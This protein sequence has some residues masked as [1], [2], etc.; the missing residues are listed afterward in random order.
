MSH[1]L[2]VNE[3]LRGSRLMLSISRESSWKEKKSNWLPAPNGPFMM[4]M[5]IYWPKPEVLDGTW[6]QPP[7]ERVK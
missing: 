5:R 6:K 7:L 3:G 2:P 4:T 1:R